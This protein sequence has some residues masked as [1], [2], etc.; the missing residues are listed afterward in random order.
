VVV[1][2]LAV[3]AIVVVHADAHPLYRGLTHHGLPLVV[4]SIVAGAVSLGLLLRRRYIAVRVSAAVAVTA[5]LWAWAVAQYPQ[6]LPGLSLTQAAATHSAL[7]A[8][9]VASAVG[10]LLLAP[11]LAWL[12]VLFQRGERQPTP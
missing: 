12:F 4:T 11:S 7:Q 9:A 2:V 1:G 3:A 6:L 8:L 10:L 5:V